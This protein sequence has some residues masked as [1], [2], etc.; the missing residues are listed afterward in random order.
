MTTKI[1]SYNIAD[2]GVVSGSY[3]N[4]ETTISAAGLIL[5]SVSGAL[6]TSISSSIV[7]ADSNWNPTGNSTASSTAAYLILTGT[8][9]D[10]NCQTLLLPNSNSN[11]YITATN[12]NLLIY[13]K[14]TNQISN[15][16]SSTLT[17]TNV[18]NLTVGMQVYGNAGIASNT[19]ITNINGN[20]ITINTLLLNTINS[21]STINFRNTNK[22]AINTNNIPADTYH[23]MIINFR[24]ARALRASAIVFT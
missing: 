18:T 14:T 3:N 20:Q 22:L 8:G 17:F 7:I 12:T 6:V 13:S 19:I 15:S 11:T 2:S 21:N 4:P 5:N 16:G 1:Q 9:L 24:G 23:I 10:S